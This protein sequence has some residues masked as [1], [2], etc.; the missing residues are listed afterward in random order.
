MNCDLSITTCIQHEGA[1]R[2]DENYM[3]QFLYY[4]DWTEPYPFLTNGDERGLGSVRKSVHIWAL[5]LVPVG[6]YVRA[7]TAVSCWATFSFM[8]YRTHCA[9]V[10]V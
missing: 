6:H 3:I 2:K 10:V 1:T 9:P 8:R 7:Q 4:G 5:S